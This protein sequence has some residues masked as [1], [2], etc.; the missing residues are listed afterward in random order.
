MHKARHQL[1]QAVALDFSASKQHPRLARRLL[2]L[3]SRPRFK[4][5][6]LAFL[7]K[8]LKQ[9]RSLHKALQVLFS[10][11]RPRPKLQQPRACLAN[12]KLPLGLAQQPVVRFLAHH[13]N[14]LKVQANSKQAAFLDKENRLDLA[15]APFSRAFRRSRQDTLSRLASLECPISK[16]YPVKMHP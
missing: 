12:L 6:R 2:Y 15:L 16:G 4:S 13:N 14:L 10:A 1:V 3:A 11:S 8:L 7:V 5:Q 9:V